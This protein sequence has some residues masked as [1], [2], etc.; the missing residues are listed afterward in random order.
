M[1]DYPYQDDDE[2]MPDIVIGRYVF[3][4]YEE[5]VLY[6]QRL[7]WERTQR[8]LRALDEHQGIPYRPDSVDGVISP[9]SRAPRDWSE[10]VPHADARRHALWLRDR[11]REP[12]AACLRPGLRLCEGVPTKGAPRSALGRVQEGGERHGQT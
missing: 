4:T 3:D 11:G 7:K 12:P 1:D 9:D 5:A 6:C 8:R 2:A 10:G